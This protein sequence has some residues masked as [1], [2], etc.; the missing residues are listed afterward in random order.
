MTF[1]SLAAATMN[2]YPQMVSRDFTH[3]MNECC[4]DARAK[5]RRLSRRRNEIRQVTP[6]P[7]C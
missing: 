2:Y 7:E 4:R 1:L 3:I 5:I 6:A